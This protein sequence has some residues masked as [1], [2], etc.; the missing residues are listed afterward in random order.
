MRKFAGLWFLLSVLVCS[1]A[2]ATPIV[3]AATGLAAPASTITFSEIVL[4]NGAFLTNQYSGLGVTF[5]NL[6]YNTQP[7]SS[8]N[9]VSPVAEN[10]NNAG[11]VFNPFSVF[12]NTTVSSAA[13]T[14]GSNAGETTR[15]TA[16]LN[17]VVVQTFDSPTNLNGVNDW[18]GFTNIAFNELRMEV[19][20]GVFNRAAAIDNLQIGATVPEPATLVLLGLGLVGLARYRRRK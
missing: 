7:V 3:A 12:F 13:L 19:L 11:G 9:I 1:P 10:F 14:F 18:F 6:W 8:G 16:L 15:F 4:A 20:A 5:N 17:N 2:Q